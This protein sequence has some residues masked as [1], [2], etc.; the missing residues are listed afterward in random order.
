MS[1][2]GVMKNEIDTQPVL[3]ERI[4]CVCVM[5]KLQHSASRLLAIDC[6]GFLHIQLKKY[7]VVLEKSKQVV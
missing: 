5:Q 7:K 3:L 6:A 2:F 1:G 4:C